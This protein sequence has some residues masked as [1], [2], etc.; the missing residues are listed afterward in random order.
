MRGSPAVF[1]TGANAPA[2]STGT[3]SA[4]PASLYVRN[5]GNV[6]LYRKSDGAPVWST[7]TRRYGS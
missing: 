3:W 4:G 1:Y 2:W 7:N 6:V 5:D